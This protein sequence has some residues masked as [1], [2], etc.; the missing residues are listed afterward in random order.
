MTTRTFDGRPLTPGLNVD[1]VDLDAGLRQADALGYLRG[2]EDGAV[3]VYA[4]Q[5]WGRGEEDGAE[6]TW[7]S[8]FGRHTLSGFRATL[9]SAVAAG[10]AALPTDDAPPSAC[11]K[12]MPFI[13][14]CSIHARRWFG[15]PF[16]S[17]SFSMSAVCRAA[18]V[19]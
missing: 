15:P 16:L 11:A 4:L 14:R 8:H 12:S 2:D 7:M 5:R 18:R 3:V 19:E 6:K 13:L 17:C 9:A 1:P 10:T